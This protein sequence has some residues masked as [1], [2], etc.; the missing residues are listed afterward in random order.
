MVSRL[1]RRVLRRVGFDT[2]PVTP[3]VAPGEAHW[4]A[5]VSAPRAFR[6]RRPSLDPRWLRR[7][8]WL[9]RRAPPLFPAPRG[10]FSFTAAAAP[11][12]LSRR[13][14][15]APRGLFA[16]AAAAMPRVGAGTTRAATHRVRTA[17]GRAARRQCTIRL[18]T[19]GGASNGDERR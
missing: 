18:S 7:L 19:N 5:T 17:S 16:S 11:R 2:L 9:R 8:R 14:L 12:G 3:Q 6:G 13:L 4:A 15:P 10:F 1:Q